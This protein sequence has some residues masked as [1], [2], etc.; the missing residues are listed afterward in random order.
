M[1]DDTLAGRLAHGSISQHNSLGLLR[2]LATSLRALHRQGLTCRRLDAQSLRIGPGDAVHLDSGP[3]G[4]RRP[5]FL[6]FADILEEVCPDPP[7]P[8]IELRQRCRESGNTALRDMGTAVLLL[9]QALATEATGWLKLRRRLLG[10]TAA[11]L[12]GGVVFAVTL[13]GATL[14]TPGRGDPE[15][16]AEI[17]LAIPVH[18]SYGVLPVDPP[19]LPVLSPD[20]RFMVVY[21]GPP[22]A[23]RLWLHRLDRGDSR[24]LPQIPSGAKPFCFSP[25]GRQLAYGAG[26]EGFRYSLWVVAV[27]GG[28]PR[29]LVNSSDRGASW[30]VDGL[31]TFTPSLNSGLFAIPAVGGEAEPVTRRDVEG[32]EISHRWPAHLPAGRGVLFTIAPRGVEGF[33]DAIV[34][35]LD[36]RTGKFKH[37]LQG[38]TYPAFLPPDRLIY[39]RDDGLMAVPFDLESL[40]V[41]GPSRRVLED[42]SMAED[43]G[44]VEYSVALD[45]TLTYV[46]RS[47]NAGKRI[48][49]W[50][51][52]DGKT[53]PI[54]DRQDTY[55]A[56]DLS[57]DDQRLIAYINS[58][59]D[60]LWLMDIARDTFGR[61][62]FGRLGA[63]EP[64]WTPDGERVAFLGRERDL[65]VANMFWMPA[66]G[67]SQAER[68]LSAPGFQIPKGFSPGGEYL[69]FTHAEDTDTSELRVLEMGGGARTFTLLGG[70]PPVHSGRIDPQG[71]WAAYRRGLVA[72][73][74]LG[75]VSFPDGQIV[76]PLVRGPVAKMRWSPQGDLFY[77]EYDP[78]NGNRLMVL[79]DAVSLAE[80]GAE[81]EPRILLSGDIIGSYFFDV[82]SDG[83][84][85]VF[86]QPLPVRWDPWV[87]AV[88]NWRAG[89]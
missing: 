76:V 31:I 51:D 36:L 32:G 42:V 19:A 49:T 55:A 69:L 3:P 79:E 70:D 80:T 26:G 4:P 63:S 85:F 44:Q 15:R 50:I 14:V 64:C 34:A 54:S 60:E 8:V 87:H 47:P 73:F 67:S 75:L 2:R 86:S 62:T 18:G 11:M 16:A 66:D 53:E 5:D 88:L 71:R 81:P 24:L 29:R 38:G 77:V 22:G 45:G 74:E 57:P 59:D 10:W 82:T 83:Q 23:R 56:I 46:K 78:E 9:D 58:Y 20:G 17:R 25:D 1:N 40:E 48:L 35:V 41:T 21:E 68:L 13:A 28:T 89:S 7:A 12:L 30:G 43:I 37:L 33:S 72:D 84:R 52:R 61:V 65:G 27:D 6:A 39:A